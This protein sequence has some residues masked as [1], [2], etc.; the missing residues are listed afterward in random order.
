MVTAVAAAAVVVVA[1]LWPSDERTPASQPRSMAVAPATPPPVAAT[2]P[3]P[4]TAPVAIEAPRA[5][6]AASRG[7]NRQIIVPEPSNGEAQMAPVA[8]DPLRQADIELEAVATPER[9]DIDAV[10]V[11]PLAIATLA[12]DDVQ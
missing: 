12:G 5:R 2:S 3:A 1:V 7:A 11:S 4:E 10:S 8:L 9:I 6:T